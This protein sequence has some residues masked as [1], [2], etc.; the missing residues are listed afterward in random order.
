[1]IN[2]ILIGYNNLSFD[3]QIIHTIADESIYNLKYEGFFA[4][5][6][7]ETKKELNYTEELKIWDKIYLFSQSL[8]KTDKFDLPY[9]DWNMKI[10]QVDLMEICNYSFKGQFPTS[11]KWLEFSMRFSK[12]EDLPYKYDEPITTEKKLNDVLKYNLND[13]LVTEEF[14]N[15]SWHLIE[16]REALIKKYGK[17]KSYWMNLAN[18]TIGSNIVLEEYCKK[19]RANR[20]KKKIIKNS[21][22]LPQQ[23]NVSNCILP[24]IE[25][26]R[27]EFVE[28][29]N[30][31]KNLVLKRSGNT[32][33]LGGEYHKSI[34]LNGLD[35]DY[36]LGGIHGAKSGWIK[37]DKDNILVSADVKSMY[38][39]ISIGNK[40]YPKHLGAKFCEV[41]E[42]LY[43]LR[44][45]HPKPD[46]LN[47][48]YKESLNSVYGKT[49]AAYHSFLTD[50]T[51]T[52]K[53]TINGQLLLTML[54]ERLLEIGTPIMF[55]T[56]GLEFLIPR[57]KLDDY[58]QI[59]KEWEGISNL[60][61]EY[62]EYDWMFIRD[63]NNYVAKYTIGKYK[64]KGA[65]MIYDDYKGVYH[66][67]P[68]AL[69]IPL[70]VFKYISEGVDLETTI[71]EHNNIYDFLYGIKGKRN[72]QYNLIRC[73]NNIIQKIDK[74]DTRALRYYVAH[75]G[76]NLMK[77]YGDGRKNYFQSVPNTSGILVSQAMNIKGHEIRYS[78]KSGAKRTRYDDLNYD[79]Y[80]ERAYELLKS[81][82]IE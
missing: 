37:S 66:K 54:G 21:K 50:P 16:M 14:A 69:I 44:K 30:D 46:P 34:N 55:N 82:I 4:A 43:E 63:V 26:N 32:F 79:F 1:M 74:I 61:L 28:V 12:M 36:G 25:L 15:R 39:F 18:S 8:F 51:Y 80:I 41:Y 57:Y 52:V 71:K 81:V 72:F 17:R 67:N 48:G 9:A 35:I 62:D 70:A 45:Q 56:D 2:P 76:S 3:G 64:R 29:F 42:S 22:T 10:K 60:E 59:C 53:T 40:I 13:V 11:L 75:N 78:L 20:D 23:I 38:P 65:F 7:L 33:K 31:F 47:L 58:Y 77:H 73:E 5:K 68:S 49:N 24:T 6:I 27:P 19:I